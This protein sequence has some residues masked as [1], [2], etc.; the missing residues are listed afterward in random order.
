MRFFITVF[1]VCFFSAGQG[2]ASEKSPTETKGPVRLPYLGPGSDKLSP[3]EYVRT[4]SQYLKESILMGFPPRTCV[5]NSCELGLAH[6]FS[7]SGLFTYPLPPGADIKAW[8]HAEGIREC[9][10]SGG[11]LAQVV[12]E[13]GGAPLRAVVVFSKAPKAMRALALACRDRDLT[14]ER[15]EAT[16]LERVAGV[17]VGYPHPLLCPE[18][19]G[20]IV[21]RLELSGD[22]KDCRPMAFEDNSWSSQLRLSEASCAAGI[23]DL[24]LAL[25]RKISPGEMAKRERERQKSRIVAVVQSKGASAKEAEAIW[26]KNYTGPIAHE[27]TL[28]G[29]AMRNIENCNQYQIGQVKLGAGAPGQS[30]PAAGQKSGTGSEKAR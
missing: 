25:Q 17:P 11:T 1:M 12:R 13:K 8:K 24:Q 16:G 14:V 26:K 5:E 21:K 29:Q 27:V 28:V 19:Q 20:L 2:L 23:E 30:E 15:H 18:S 10:E 4:Y 6:L 7:S 3:E 9:Y 22:R